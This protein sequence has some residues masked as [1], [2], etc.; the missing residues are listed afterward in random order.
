MNATLLP[1]M[2]FF[3]RTTRQPAADAVEYAAC[4]HEIL[5]TRQ[6]PR[7]ASP[8]QLITAIIRSPA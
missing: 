6:L 4:Q 8:T 2:K 1:S 7:R 5:D 3:H